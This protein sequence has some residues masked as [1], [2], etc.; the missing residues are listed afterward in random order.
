MV[1]RRWR[2]NGHVTDVV[3]NGGSMVVTE[4]STMEGE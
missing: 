2:E 4:V 3:Y 1:T